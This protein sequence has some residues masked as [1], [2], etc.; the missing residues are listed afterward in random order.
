[1]NPIDPLRPLSLDDIVGPVESS[2][3]AYGGYGP[4]SCYRPY[5]WEMP[6]TPTQPPHAPPYYERPPEREERVPTYEDSMRTAQL[7]EKIYRG[8]MDEID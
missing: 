1:M 4:A 8:H 3:P 5:Q 2:P 7:F 6:W